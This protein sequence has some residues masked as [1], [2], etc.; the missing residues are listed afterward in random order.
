MTLFQRYVYRQALWPFIG[1]L[2]A[3]FGLALL[4]QSLTN[5][6]L[7]ADQRDT[8]L[9]FV[10]IT[11]LAMPQVI[12]L[13]VPVA[14]FIACAMALNRLNSDSELIIG[15]ASGMSRA[16]RLSPVLRLAV[17][18]LLLNLVINLFVQPMSF[19][20]MR[21]QVFEI[22]T[23]IAASLMRPGEFIAMGEH[24][25]FYT[26]EIGDDRVLRG[27]FIED[28]RGTSA[29][30]YAAR[31][32]VIARSD[33]GPVMLLEDGV[34]SQLDE[35]GT[36]ANLSFDR[37]E[38]DLGAF[39]DTSSA[40][41]FKESDRFLPELLQPSAADRARARRPEDLAAEG[42]YRLSSPLYVIAFAL[43]AAAAFMSVEHRR[44]GYMRFIVIAGAGALLLRL[45]G[46]A[47][48][49]GASNN[50]DL[51]ILQYLVPLAGAAAALWLIARPDRSARQRRRAV[52]APA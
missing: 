48:Q 34:L 7:L 25:S 39:V 15:A 19:R 29:T 35:T 31:R 36:L 32:A 2:A 22:R 46:F 51:N 30:A 28:G 49:A 4:T 38:F 52:R 42:H 45:A 33:R 24:V 17:Y 44:T 8:A 26:R 9:R 23:D 21:E 40:F 47:V 27:V 1:A 13:L 3:L 37:Y 14:V 5:L 12:A 41:F 16:Q 20:Q 50:S 6:N 43:I 11:M 10:W 18:A